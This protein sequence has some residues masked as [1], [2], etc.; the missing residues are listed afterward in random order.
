[1]RSPSFSVLPRIALLL[2]MLPAALPGQNGD[3]QRAIKLFEDRNYPAARS[4]LSAVLA[5][6]GRDAKAL[7][8][9]GRIAMADNQSAEAVGWFEKA[10]KADDTSSQYHFWLANA[11][12]QEAQRASKFRQP[13]LARRVKSE[14]ERAVHLDPRSVDARRGLMDFYLIAPGVMGGSKEKAREQAAEIAKISPLQ[15]RFATAAIAQREKD[16]PAAEREYVA[17]VTENPD[18]AIAYL[19]L[20]VYYQNTQRW[21]EAFA[22]LDRLLAVKPNEVRAHYQIGRAAALSGKHLDRGEQSLKLWIAKPPDDAVVTTR[23]GAHYR[24]GMVYDKQG[25]R[26]LAR[27]EYE[28]ALRINARN[29]DARKALEKLKTES[30]G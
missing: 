22:V 26:D 25:N 24:L 4:E 15:G 3:V 14:F 13:F 12:G 23:S 27:A 9:M 18:S 10:V 1:M 5:R 17:A 30:R 16:V 28:Q 2:S 7:Y 29:E 6:N 19:A 21:D 20:S 8:Y 11:L